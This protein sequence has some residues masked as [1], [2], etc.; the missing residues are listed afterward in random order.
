MNSTKIPPQNLEAEQSVL[1]GLL[2]DKTAIIKVADVLKS[3]DFYKPAHSIIYRSIL[4]LYEKNEPIDIVTVTNELKEDGGIERIGGSSYLTSLIDMVP[5]SSHIDHYAKL[6][7]EKKILRDLINTSAQITEAAFNPTDELDQVLSDI[8]QRI[9]AI[10]QHSIS[11]R[12][13]HVKEGLHSAYERIEMLHDG[14]GKMRGV[15]TGF[16]GLDSILSGLQKSDLVILGA[17]P[18]VGKTSLCLDMIRSVGIHE[19]KPVGIFSLEMSK[20]QVIDRLIAAEGNVPLWKLRTGQLTNETDFQLI[21]QALDKLSRAPIYI[22]DT[23]SPNILQMRAMARRLQAEH[24]LSL[25]VIDYLQLI[26]PRNSNAGTVQQITEISRGLK[27][28][29]REL[30]VPVIAL[31]QLSRGV[32]QRDNKVPRLSDLRDSGSIEQDA[33]VVMFIY[34]KDR[35]TTDLDPD[36]ENSTEII[37]AKHRNGPLGTVKLKFNPETASFRELDRHHQDND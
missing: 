6:V 12:F 30:D 20:E 26:Q 10:S 31:S 14:K 2:I 13:S 15:P 21:Q 3:D 22:D 37:I 24:N 9:F 4:K 8:E 19:Q 23:P 34:R 5:T 36:E 25:I 1:G 11:Q 28:L 18:S 16:K 35:N 32:D 17:R 7:R 27:G 33:D 29:A